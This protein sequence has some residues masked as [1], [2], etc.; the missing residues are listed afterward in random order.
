MW[1]GAA[2]MIRNESRQLLMILQGRPEEEK[3]WS[4]PA[5]GL[6]DGEALEECCAREVWEETGHRV[7]VGAYLHEKRGISRGYPYLV[8]YYEAEI[9]GGAPVIQD[10]DGLI[11]DIR[12]MSAPEIRELALTYPEDRAFLL[13]YTERGETPILFRTNPLSVR[14]LQ[15]ADAPLLQKWLNDPEVLRYYE[16]RDRPYTAEMIQ[17]DFYSPEDPAV[18]CILEHSGTP[19]GYVQFYTVD[20]EERTEYGLQERPGERCFGMDQFIGEPS[21]WNRGIGGQLVRGMLRYLAEEQGAQ[22]VVMDPQAWNERALACYEKS[23]FRRVKL[24]PKHERHEG[25]LRDCWLVE[26]RP[27][28]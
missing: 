9:T 12:W 19:I 13:E 2:A 10:P 26:W 21:Y 25:E 6:N 15:D 24:L 23:G 22:R 14:R 28:A 16:G 4:V 17:A 3:K 8:K 20:G 11:Y 18:K 27:E 7:Q 1:R 5:G